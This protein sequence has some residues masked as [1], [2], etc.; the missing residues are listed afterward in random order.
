MRKKTTTIEDLKKV[1]EVL[2]PETKVEKIYNTLNW[3]NKIESYCGVNNLTPEDL[4]AFHV[5]GSK[6]AVKSKKQGKNEENKE[7]IKGLNKSNWRKDF[8]KAKTGYSPTD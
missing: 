7:S 5:A 6:N 3:I 4:I 1:D 8:I 2:I